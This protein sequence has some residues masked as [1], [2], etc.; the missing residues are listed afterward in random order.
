MAEVHVHG[1]DA[2]VAAMERLPKELLGKNGG[3]IR[4]ALV[5]AALIVKEDARARAAA[6]GL[7]K[8]G[9]MISNIVHEVDRNPQRSGANERVRVGVRGGSRIPYADTKANRR[10]RIVGKTYQTQGSTFYW[11]FHEFGAENLPARPFL[12]PAFYAHT[13][14][15]IELITALSARQVAII[16]RRLAAKQKREARAAASRA[17]AA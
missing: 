8:T 16:A 13:G 17:K 12:R 15:N 10:L 7:F 4:K 5:A 11:R 1:I 14:S 3:P 6:H 9:A 2:L